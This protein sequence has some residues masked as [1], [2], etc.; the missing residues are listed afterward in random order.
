MY[1]ITEL[2]GFLVKRKLE[3]K[4]SKSA[5]IDRLITDDPKCFENLPLP[6]KKKKAADKP[7]ADGLQLVTNSQS[8]SEDR[9]R[10]EKSSI[11]EPRSETQPIVYNTFLDLILGKKRNFREPLRP[12]RPAS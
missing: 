2:R 6:V 10:D 3:T 9:K 5:L 8:A 1:T 12:H 11:S 4:G 7:E